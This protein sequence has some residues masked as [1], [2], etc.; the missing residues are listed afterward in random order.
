MVN[1]PQKI[2]CKA[3][4]KRTG[5]QCQ[6]WAVIGYQVCYHHG[7]NPK[8]RGGAPKGSKNAMTYGA[9]INRLLNDEER[10]LFELFYN[11]LHQDFKLNESSDEMSAQMACIYFVRLVRAIEGGNAETMNKVDLL[12]S[13]KLSELKATKD[14]REGEASS[15]Q[16][17]P[18]EWAASLLEEYRK[19]T[20]KSGKT[21]N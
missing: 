11:R 12:L 8:N 16:T 10:E 13:R 18:A 20:G 15:L 17:T 19:L 9:Y 14:K 5:K 3:K 21:E 4:S 7:A 6:Q 1:E 2:R